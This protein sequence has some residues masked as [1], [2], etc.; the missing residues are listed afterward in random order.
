MSR[1]GAGGA[2]GH[3]ARRPWALA[4]CRRRGEPPPPDFSVGGEAATLIGCAAV[5]G[6]LMPPASFRFSFL[7]RAP[8]PTAFCVRTAGGGALVSS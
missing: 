5:G 8:R 1:H 2:R 7:S 3:G 6:F 4:R